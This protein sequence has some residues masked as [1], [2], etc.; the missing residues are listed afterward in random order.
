MRFRVKP[1]TLSSTRKGYEHMNSLPGKLP[2]A[3]ITISAGDR[4]SK[5]VLGLQSITAKSNGTQY[6]ALKREKVLERGPM[7]GSDIETQTPSSDLLFNIIIVLRL[8]RHTVCT[9]KQM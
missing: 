4:K 6:H 9:G 8:V 2:I 7:L 3:I 5:V 1:I